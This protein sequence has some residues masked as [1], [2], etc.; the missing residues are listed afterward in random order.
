M[1]IFTSLNDVVAHLGMT[2]PDSSSNYSVYGLKLSATAI[3]SHIDHANTWVNSLLDG[4]D[5]DPSDSRYAFAQLTALAKACLGV[6]V[7]SVG[8]SLVGA[9]DYFLGDMRVARTAPYASA[10]KTAIDCY[11]ADVAENIVNLISAV[12][13][14]DCTGHV[15][16]YQGPSL[17]P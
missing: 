11:R 5:L 14:K 10:I 8:G 7:A 4:V 6:L 3:Q 9:Y 15:P 17:E 16:H 13:S 12:S 1:I 2:G